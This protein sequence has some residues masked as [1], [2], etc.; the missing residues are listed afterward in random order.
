MNEPRPFELYSGTTEISD[1]ITAH[2]EGVAPPAQTQGEQDETPTDGVSPDFLSEAVTG[3]SLAEDVAIAATWNGGQ[4]LFHGFGDKV[5]GALAAAY[6]VFLQ[7]VNGGD[8]AVEAVLNHPDFPQRQRIH[9]QKLALIALQLAAK[10]SDDAQHGLCSD[11]RNMLE[12]AALKQIE[13]GAFAERMSTITLKTCKDFV[14]G[15]AKERKQV[16][17]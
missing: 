13:P 14:R 12:Y 7:L 4:G 3:R 1:D 10:P 8:E 15:R 2:H 6:P 11:Y 16:S 17:S 5:N 9:R